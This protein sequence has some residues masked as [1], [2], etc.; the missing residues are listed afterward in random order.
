[1]SPKLRLIGGPLHGQTREFPYDEA[2]VRRVG[3]D[4]IERLLREQGVGIVGEAPDPNGQLPVENY[5]LAYKILN[6]FEVY[7]VMQNFPI[8]T[9]GA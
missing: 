6:G 4:E 5:R 1:M 3:A 9:E 7:A 2:T 8:V